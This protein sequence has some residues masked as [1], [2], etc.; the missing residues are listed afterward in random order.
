MS[1]PI[2]APK[3]SRRTRSSTT[4]ISNTFVIPSTPR[5]IL[6][7]SPLW[8]LT[9]W[10][11]NTSIIVLM[12]SLLIIKHLCVVMFVYSFMYFVN[13]FCICSFSKQRNLFF[14]VFSLLWSSSLISYNEVIVFFNLK[15][16]L[17]CI[18]SEFYILFIWFV[19]IVRSCNSF[20]LSF[21]FI[22]SW[23]LCCCIWGVEHKMAKTREWKWVVGNREEK[24]L[25]KFFF[26]FYR[27]CFLFV[28]CIFLGSDTST[29]HKSRALTHIDAIFVFKSC[30]YHQ[31]S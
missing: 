10:L 8:N 29:S 16:H 18:F 5:L 24:N 15:E 13:L 31:S 12:N 28:S 7:Y 2:T 14:F 1:T 3:S 23:A 6:R 9:I 22:F 30:W 20:D 27:S 26:H 25:Y 11:R 4:P 21:I 19:F 17:F